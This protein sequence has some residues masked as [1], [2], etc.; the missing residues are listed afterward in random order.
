MVA[1]PNLEAR[2][3]GDLLDNQRIHGRGSE[4]L[5]VSR[6]SSDVRAHG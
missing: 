3:S 1:G 2:I 6:L 4:C 5:L